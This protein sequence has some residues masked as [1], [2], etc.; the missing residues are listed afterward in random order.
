MS[1]AC[2]GVFGDAK[3]GGEEAADEINI[4]PGRGDDDT[5]QIKLTYSA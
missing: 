5:T 2:D 1:G 3:L 4:Y